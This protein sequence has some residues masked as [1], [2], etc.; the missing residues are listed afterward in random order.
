MTSYAEMEKISELV[1]S[2]VAR[3]INILILPLFM[4]KIVFSNI[5]AEGDK[6]FSALKS[7]LIYFLLISLFPYV[8]NL[9]FAI[10][11][12]FMP[13]ST[14]PLASTNLISDSTVSGMIP[15]A[16]DR[17]L[18]LLLAALYWMSFHLHIFFMLIMC[19]MAPL[20]FLTSTILGI[21]M[22]IE[23][24]MGLLI[25]GSSWPIIWHGFDQVHGLLASVQEDQFGSR[26]L[27][28]MI[29]V[30]KGI[31]P[32]TFALTAIKSPA[33]KMITQSVRF[34]SSGV[35]KTFQ[36]SRSLVQ[37]HSSTE[38]TVSTSQSSPLNYKKSY[39]NKSPRDRSSEVKTKNSPSSKTELNPEKV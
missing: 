24:F 22:G 15:L 19:S 7:V 23:I 12:S 5:I 11:D 34:T 16:V 39:S 1:F 37:R 14:A 26:C 17:V 10:P 13:K 20:I 28:L 4:G 30:L 21:G 31:S 29:T 2:E 32:L 25:I 18:E 3:A 27:E 38:N 33:G 9:L 6:A 36:V 35:N 8:L